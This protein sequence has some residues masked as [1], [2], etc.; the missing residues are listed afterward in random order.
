[1]DGS[2]HSQAKRG[3]GGR[4]AGSNDRA[5]GRGSWEK[6]GRG[7]NWERA[8][9]IPLTAADGVF[10]RELADQAVLGFVTVRE[11]EKPV[12]GVLESIGIR[13]PS[14]TERLVHISRAAKK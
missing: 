4:P 3:T 11:G 5:E 6:N 2:L 7:I 13:I 9:M 12:D 1:V 8:G 10:R 14:P